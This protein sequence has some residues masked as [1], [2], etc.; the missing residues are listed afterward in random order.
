MFPY[1]SCIVTPP[2]Q[3]SLG[4]PFKFELAII[5]AHPVLATSNLVV[6]LEASKAY[7]WSDQRQLALP[8]IKPR[9]RWS[10]Q[11]ETTAIAGTGWLPLPR[12]LIFCDDNGMRREMQVRDGRDTSRAQPNN[13]GLS[14]FVRP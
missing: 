9:E 8:V 14:V 11:Y 3:T 10:Y 6:Q 13:S 1:L 12:F 5:N 2:T 4:Q 7:A